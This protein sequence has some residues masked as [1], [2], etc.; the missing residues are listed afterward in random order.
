SNCRFITCGMSNRNQRKIK[1]SW[2]KAQ[3]IR[4]KFKVEGYT[5]KELILL[6]GIPRQLLYQILINKIWKAKEI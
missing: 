6:Y 2:E 4:Q 5:K 1:L 3:E